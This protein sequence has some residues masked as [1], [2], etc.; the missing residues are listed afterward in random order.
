[1]KAYQ[2][3]AWLGSPQAIV[4]AETRN[5]ARHITRV[6]ALDAGYTVNWIE[7]KARRRPDLDHLH[8]RF[9]GRT[10]WTVALVEKETLCSPSSQS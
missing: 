5:K 7:I 2:T 9:P 8:A 10:C 6:A 3:V 4:F 1:M